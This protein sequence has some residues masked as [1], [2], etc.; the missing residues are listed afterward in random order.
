MT[1]TVND[2]LNGFY[3]LNPNAIQQEDEIDKKVNILPLALELAAMDYR[4][5]NFYTNLNDEQRKAI[6]LWVLMRWMS[7]SRGDAEQHLTL[8]NDVVNVDFSVISKHPELQWKLLALCGTSKQQY[9]DWVPPGKKSKKNKV[10]E[11]LLQ[12]YPLMKDADLELLQQINTQ[13]DF[14][15]FFK[16]NAL[17]DKTIKEIFKP[18]KGKKQTSDSTV[19]M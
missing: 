9:R 16:A 2:W 3:E 5:K 19:R 18:A 1:D 14:E 6:S 10:E 13:E 8:V 7:S 11:A 15:E 4:D 17:D 12:F